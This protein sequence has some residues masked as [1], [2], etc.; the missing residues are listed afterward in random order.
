M[1]FTRDM[2][3]RSNSANQSTMEWK[4][5]SSMLETQKISTETLVW[6]N[7]SNLK[8]RKIIKHI[9]CEQP[10]IARSHLLL[11][12]KILWAKY[13]HSNRN[14]CNLDFCEGEFPNQ[15]PL[16][17]S[18]EIV[19]LSNRKLLTLKVQVVHDTLFLYWQ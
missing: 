10:L 15:I 7:Y 16:N 19:T 17:W 8:N 13:S 18:S 5:L 1:P 9:L 12:A 14:L 3:M 2:P 4:T 6:M 11:F